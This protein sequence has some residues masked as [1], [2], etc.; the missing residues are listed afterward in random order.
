MAARPDAG[1]AAGEE[2]GTEEGTALL[3]AMAALGVLQV[4][5]S[6]GEPLLRKDFWLL[7]REARRLRLGLRIF[8]N[9]LVLGGAG[10]QVRAQQIAELHPLAVEISVYGAVAATHEEVTGVPG[11]WAAALQ[12]LARLRRCGV[13]TAWKT[14]LMRCNAGEIEA[15]ADLARQVGAAFRPDPL[16]TSPVVGDQALRCEVLALRASE[17]EL[18][19]ALAAWEA[20]RRKTCS[21]TPGG[22]PGGA[23][24]DGR[25]MGPA[26]CTL[27]HSG[28]LVDPWGRVMPCVEV[29]DVVGCVRTRPLRAIWEDTDAWRPYLALEQR[30][31]QGAC[32]RCAAATWCARCGGSVR[33]ETGDWWGTGAGCC[34]VAWARK[35]ILD[36]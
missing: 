9:G 12:A 26:V 21:A 14:P 35:R 10:G 7:A 29:R 16:L 17:T 36:P 11:S 23:Q 1:Q 34:T 18:A 15:M 3:K 27:G 32:A 33:N 2:L 30:A 19:G 25:R 28:L 24:H 8:S 20:V 13:R 5:F 31:A 4:T 22:S 6:G